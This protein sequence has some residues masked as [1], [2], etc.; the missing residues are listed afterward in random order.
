MYKMRTRS[1]FSL[2]RLAHNF[3]LFCRRQETRIPLLCTAYNNIFPLWG[4]IY[5]KGPP[6][7]LAIGYWLLAIVYWLLAIGYWLARVIKSDKEV[8]CFA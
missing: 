6:C 3:S 7:L 1:D 5:N 8:V 4:L 2:C